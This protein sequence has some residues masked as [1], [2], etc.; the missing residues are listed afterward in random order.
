MLTCY[1]YTFLNECLTQVFFIRGNV[2]AFPKEQVYTDIITLI[3]DY[4]K[5]YWSPK[6][7]VYLQF[8]RIMI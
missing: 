7:C 1:F 6:R 2:V 3:N 4:K 8:A 5:P